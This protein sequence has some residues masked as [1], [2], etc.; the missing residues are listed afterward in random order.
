[1]STKYPMPTIW[2][3]APDGGGI[4]E[5]DQHVAGHTL[6]LEPDDDIEPTVMPDWII[7]VLGF[8]PLQEPGIKEP[9]A[10]KQ[11]LIFEDA[12]Q[13]SDHPRGQPKNA[14]QFAKGAG[15]GPTTNVRQDKGAAKVRA[16][17]G[18][19]LATILSQRRSD[20]PTPNGQQPGP[21]KGVSSTA[22]TGNGSAVAFNRALSD[23]FYR[24]ISK[25]VKASNAGAAVHVYEPGEYKAMRCYLTPDKSAGYALNGDDIVSVFKDP[26]SPHKK[27]AI[28]ALAQAVKNG[29]RRLDCFDTV[30]PG[31]Y[32]NNHFRAVSRVKFNDEYAPEGW[33]YER[34]APFNKGRPDVVFMVYDPNHA[35][36][37]KPGDGDV[38]EDY[39]EAVAV[40][41]DAV[42][43]GLSS[44]AQLDFHHVGDAFKEADHPRGQ[45]DNKGQFA[46]TPGGGESSASPTNA[47]KSNSLI[48][49]YWE[50][51]KAAEAL[52][53]ST[54]ESHQAWKAIKEAHEEYM[55]A[56]RSEAPP[57]V[58]VPQGKV[59]KRPKPVSD[60]ALSEYAT[61]Y[62]E[63]F[64]K[65]SGLWSVR[66]RLSE[67][68]SRRLSAVG[69]ARAAVMGLPES[70]RNKLKDTTVKNVGTIPS[71]QR[72]VVE[73]KGTGGW[74]GMY[75][76]S[77]DTAYVVDEVSTKDGQ[78]FVLEDVGAVTVHELGHAL[79]HKLGLSGLGYMSEGVSADKNALTP[80]QTRASEY[81]LQSSS[82]MVAECYSMCFSNSGRAFGMPKSEAWDAFKNTRERLGALLQQKGLDVYVGIIAT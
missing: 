40:Q 66:E 25:A 38:A 23:N 64:R 27:V 6:D 30:L 72:M 61:M 28:T 17:R 49:K 8:D 20:D 59:I 42:N 15:K 73:N 31:F 48:Q 74:A 4:I 71:S 76:G 57:P 33:D 69:Q 53:P 68:K 77:E 1:M 79:D 63:D 19:Q 81:Y 46:S 37:Y 62:P 65:E 39:D 56:K 2:T 7:D 29:G 45:P 5:Y 58:N 24:A 22:S 70:H 35:E 32:S 12:F 10:T 3:I 67:Y 82:E 41:K 21:D 52:D 54:P 44:R 13:E 26:N 47:T 51:K 16:Q 78:T 43:G 11:K 34:M 9:V 14:G 36:L 18:R 60:D 55:T 80:D 50:M 75:R